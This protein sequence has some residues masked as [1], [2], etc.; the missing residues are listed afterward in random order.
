MSASL[1]LCLLRLVVQ[2]DLSLPSGNAS[3]DVGLPSLVSVTTQ[4][5]AVLL[6][7]QYQASCA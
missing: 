3:D 4:P 5:L 2:S 7:L 1:A 6:V